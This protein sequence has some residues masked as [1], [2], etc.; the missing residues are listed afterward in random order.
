VV[1]SARPAQVAVFDPTT[2]RLARAHSVPVCLLS[3]AAARDRS[4]DHLAPP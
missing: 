4:A 3:A 1:A 2:R